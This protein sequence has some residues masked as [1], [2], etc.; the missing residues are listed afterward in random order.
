MAN[1]HRRSSSIVP[2]DDEFGLIGH[3]FGGNGCNVPV[4][5]TLDPEKRTIALVGGPMLNAKGAQVG[6]ERVSFE[7][8]FNE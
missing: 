8:R 7:W 5:V 4:T 6:T 1:I 3:S 2:R